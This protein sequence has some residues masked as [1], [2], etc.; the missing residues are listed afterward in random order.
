MVAAAEAVVRKLM[1]LHGAK[2]V[3]DFLD[4]RNVTQLYNK[5]DRRERNS[6]SLSDIARLCVI[7]PHDEILAVLREAKHRLTAEE[8]LE[9]LRI[10]VMNQY[11]KSG[12]R[13]LAE[14]DG[15]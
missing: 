11:G 2:E 3:A 9:R 13:L 15:Q 1:A 8:R 5:V 10:A 6:L 4:L 14:V 7:D 12:E